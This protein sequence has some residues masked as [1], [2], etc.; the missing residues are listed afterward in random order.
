[1]ENGIIYTL[2]ERD[3]ILSKDAIL[4]EDDT[5]E[6]VGK[7]SEIKKRYKIDKVI[8]AN[9]KLIMPGLIDLHY[10]SALG[11]GMFG[12]EPLEEVLFNYGYPSLRKLKP[13]QAYQGALCEYYEAIKEGVTTV[14]D[15]YVQMESIVNKRAR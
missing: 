12:D 6:V 15:M 5:I 1:M 14:H 7:V 11:K 13:E 2:D 10:H 9:N 3:R 8:N 4:I